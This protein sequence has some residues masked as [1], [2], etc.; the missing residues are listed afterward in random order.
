MITLTPEQTVSVRY[1]LEVLA[2]TAITQQD[3]EAAGHALV[4]L[5]ALKDAG[6]GTCVANVSATRP[7]SAS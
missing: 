3:T 4:L 5:T 2:D 1:A 7:G 6:M